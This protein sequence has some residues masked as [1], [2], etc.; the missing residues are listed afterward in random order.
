MLGLINGMMLSK[1]KLAMRLKS[2]TTKYVSWDSK[3]LH[4]NQQF[5]NLNKPI[6]EE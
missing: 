3:G 6:Q 1:I 5:A 2:V 4:K